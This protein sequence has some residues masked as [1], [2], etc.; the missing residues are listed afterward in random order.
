MLYIFTDC[1][2]LCFQLYL[3]FPSTVKYLKRR[4]VVSYVRDMHSYIPH[5]NMSTKQNPTTKHNNPHYSYATKS[6]LLL[7]PSVFFV[8]RPELL[9][10]A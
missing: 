8:S 5:L 10:G 1:Q 7:L 6:R 3:H 9:P 4:S 2:Y